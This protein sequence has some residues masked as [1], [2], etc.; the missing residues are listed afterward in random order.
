MSIIL[1]NRKFLKS[2]NYNIND[3]IKSLPIINTRIELKKNLKNDY[4]KS[5]YICY[6]KLI[7]KQVVVKFLL[8][9]NITNEQLEIYNFLMNNK[10][11][12]ICNILEIGEIDQFILI[13]M[14]YV[15]GTNLKDY[16]KNNEI[17]FDL[18]LK[19]CEGL[20]FL[21]NNRIL[22]GDIKSSNI[23]IKD[24]QIN[25]IDFDNSKLIKKEYK[26]DK[27]IVGTFPFISREVIKFNRYYLKSDIWQ[28]GSVLLFLIEN[29]EINININV[30][31]KSE[32]T[33]QNY[34]II[35]E[36]NLNELKNENKNMVEILKLMLKVNVFERS[37]IYDIIKR[38]KNFLYIN[39]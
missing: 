15:N 37:D 7:K 34:K 12:Y 22:H 27:N 28:L 14:E 24:K 26:Y 36:I 23:I 9:D 38:L 35:K 25:I 16:I 31:S 32:I 20:K 4:R 3:C 39:K 2:E 8:K 21:H 17:N 19:I 18:L 29:I 30:K 33:E 5:I 11:D 13:F 6:D 1:K 10:N